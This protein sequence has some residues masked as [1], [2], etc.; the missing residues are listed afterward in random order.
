MKTLSKFKEDLIVEGGNAI[1][2]VGPINQEN[3]IATVNALYK[4]FLGSLK[5]KEKDV[6][7]LGSTGKKG[8]KQTSGDIDIAISAKTLLKSNKINTFSDMVDLIVQVIKR[9]GYVYK[10]LRSI[11]IVSFGYPIEN[12]DGHQANE[13]VQVDFMLVQDVKFASFAFYSPSY[14]ESSFKGLFRNELNYAVAKNAKLKVNK[15]DPSTNTPIEWSRYWFDMQGGL[16]QGSQTNVSKKTGKIVKSIRSLSKELVSYDPDTVVQFL[17]G[18]TVK[19]QDV[20]TFENTLKA[21]LSS[22]FPYASKRK[23]ILKMASEGIQSKGFP[24]PDILSKVL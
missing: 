18:D 6:A 11:G 5:I 13:T 12:V 9:K 10:D 23:I 17:Y 3:S 4:E 21:V 24:I 8:P 1:P 20:M 19:A 7:M 15:I 16:M 22:K 2:G 14:L